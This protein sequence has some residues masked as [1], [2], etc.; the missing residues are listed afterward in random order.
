[1]I[2]APVIELPPTEVVERVAAFGPALDVVVAPKELDRNLLIASWNLRAFGGLTKKWQSAEDDSPK[3]DLADVLAIAAMLSRFDVVAVQEVRSDLRALR[4]LLKALGPDWG[5]TLTD[6]TKGKAGNDERLAFLFDTRRV[7]L[8]GLACEL[9]VPEDD[10]HLSP[11]AFA[12]QFA[13]TPYAVSFNSAGKTFI[14]VTLH[15]VYG[16][17][18]SDRVGELTAIAEWL[19]SWAAEV[20]EWGHNLICLGDFNIDR[21][22]DPLFQAFTSTGLTAPARVGHRAPDDLRRSGRRPL[23]RPD[24]LVRRRGE[25]PGPVAS[26][27]E[28]RH[29][30]LRAALAAGSDDDA[31]VVADLGP[32][33]VVGGVLGAMTEL[34][35]QP[36]LERAAAP[37]QRS[38]TASPRDRDDRKPEEGIAL[39]LSG[40]GY[41]AMLFHL[42]ALWRLNEAGYLPQARAGLER[43]R[44]LDHRRRA[45]AQ[46]GRARL[47]RRRRRATNFDE[48]IVEPVRAH[49]RRDDRLAGDPARACCC[50]A[51]LGERVVAA[52]RK[53]LFGA[54]T[55]QDS[56]DSPRF[57]FNATNLQ[58]GALWRFSKPYLWDYRV[59]EVKSP[60]GRARRG[61]RRL[62]GVPAVPVAGRARLRGRSHVDGSGDEPGTDGNLQ[63]PPFTTRVVLAD[64]G[65]YDNLGLET[66]WKRYTSVL[67]SDGGG[68]YR[69]PAE[70]DADLAAAGLPRPRRDRQP[71]AQP[72]QA[73]ADRRL[74]RR[75]AR[76]HLLGHPERHRRLR[77]PDLAPVPGGGDDE[78][79][80][81]LHPSREPRPRIAG[82]ARQLGVRDRGHGSP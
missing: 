54:T 35:H 79:R 6:V 8:S 33:P 55:L 19:A 13:R 50:R 62:V 2:A 46:L 39:C 20:A 3:R 38:P 52:Y 4:Y 14:L 76:G 57:V 17:A 37:V 59:G 12:R 11:T 26:V 61:R 29:L 68:Q 43:L 69:R 75:P 64:G 7:T 28:S 23:L 49:G 67:V 31:A 1:M 21:K 73:P 74:S 71:G 70:P 5:F 22:D 42:G 44:R 36:D 78:A 16:Q 47:R 80:R 72:A 51:S 15:V 30:R 40:G 81:D 65:V 27:D 34:L 48:Q 32:L 63:H 25:R 56:A 60:D 77:P 9:V 66:A 24:R 18:P 82:T 45:G 58:S 41:R 53:H 10:P